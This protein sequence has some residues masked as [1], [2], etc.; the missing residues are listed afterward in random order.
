MVVPGTYTVRLTIADSTGGPSRTYSKPFVVVNDPRVTVAP[1]DLAA[2]AALWM[3]LR[4]KIKATVD[5]AEQI[6]A[7]ERQLDARVEQSKS[8]PYAARIKAAAP[9]LR[10]KLE[11]VRAELVEVHSHADEITLH[12][13][14]KLYNQLLTL[15]EQALSGDGAPTQHMRDS[16]AQLAAGVDAQLAKLRALEGG[17]VAAFNRL[18]K[19]LDVPAIITAAPATR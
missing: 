3:Q 9:P 2:Q 4:D 1:A 15:N 17:E 12:Y 10:K 6:E 19:Q 5:A 7:M 8:Q 11:A 16:F 13:P 18:V 14:V